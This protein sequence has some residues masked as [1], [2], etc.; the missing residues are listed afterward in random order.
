MNKLKPIKVLTILFALTLTALTYVSYTPIKAEEINSGQCEIYDVGCDIASQSVEVN[1][2]ADKDCEMYVAL[3]DANNRLISAKKSEIIG[4]SEP[5]DKVFDNV[6][7]ENIG[8]IKAFLWGKSSNEALCESKQTSI[9]RRDWKYAGSAYYDK[10]NEQYILTKDNKTWSAG[11]IWYDEEI[12][13]DFTIELDYY[14]GST[15]RAMDGGDGMA[16]AFYADKNNLPLPAGELGFS[17]CGGYGVEIDTWANT[18]IGDPSYTHIG[19]I[20]NDIRNHI[21]Y[22]KLSRAED[23]S[24]HHLKIRVKDYICTAFVDGH[25]MIA[26]KVGETGYKY[27]GI[28]AGTGDGVNLHAVKNIIITY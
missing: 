5:L 4:F 22:A 17:G 15:D 23:E 20:K 10:A 13:G 25:K 7:T 9:G 27:L 8:C 28:T 2:I 16:V 6:E 1:Y 11:A 3:Y 24:W 12:A 14:T 26:G 18:D 21:I 19:L